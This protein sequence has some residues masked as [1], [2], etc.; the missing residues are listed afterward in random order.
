MI[1]PSALRD[2]ARRL[3]WNSMPLKDLIP[4]LNKAAD[5]IEAL[6][7][8]VKELTPLQGNWKPLQEGIDF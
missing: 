2:I 4:A 7:A 6:E 5:R 1:E 3:R 8:Q